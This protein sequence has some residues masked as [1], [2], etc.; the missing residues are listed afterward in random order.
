M[1]KLLL[2]YSTFYILNLTFAQGDS[3]R[4]THTEETNPLKNQQY[5]S[6]YDYA[7]MKNEPTKWMIK[8]YGIQL[9]DY[10]IGVERKLTTSFSITLDVA[11]NKV[12]DFD[13]SLKRWVS[14]AEIRWY[15][16]LKNRIRKAKSIHHFS[17]NYFALR[18]ETAWKNSESEAAWRKEVNNRELSH[19]YNKAWETDY[20]S[21][22]Y[23]TQMSLMYGMQ[24]RFFRFGFL[25]FFVSLNNRTGRQ[26]HRNV[27]FLNGN[28]TATKPDPNTLLQT[29]EVSP[30]NYWYLTS[31][32]KFGVAFADLKKALPSRKGEIFSLSE[33]EQQLWKINW[34]VLEVTSSTQSLNSSIGYEHKIG[35]SAFSINT[36]LDLSFYH[37]FG[38]NARLYDPAT[39]TEFITNFSYK[40]ISGLLSIQPRW[41][42]LQNLP[43]HLRPAGNNL[44]G[45]Y[46]G[47][48]TTFF[49]VHTHTV[50]NRYSNTTGDKPQFLNTGLL[51]GY[52]RKLFKN[53]FIDFNLSKGLFN[54]YPYY[55]SLWVPNEL[56]AWTPHSLQKNNFIFDF[57]LGFVL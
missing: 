40:S 16:D 42:F 33:N 6:I 32:F 55:Y 45:V 53:G 25:D 44:S 20:Y 26:I 56:Y 38:K 36:C 34:P 49:G 31:G 29:V 17:G 11:H 46:V 27:V 1:K 12:A 13:H 3:I 23:D 47:S 8:A 48:N 52:Q 39:K 24:R 2:L 28:N 5:V 15:Y 51:L 41:Y 4:I 35:Q 10:R 9:L 57:K 37:F 54:N 7:L 21:S 14:G 18:Y 22:Y 30:I 19:S 43:S 50:T